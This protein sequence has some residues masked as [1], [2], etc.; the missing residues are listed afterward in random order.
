MSAEKIILSLLANRK[1]FHA[2]LEPQGR[3][4]LWLERFLT[5]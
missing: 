3:L 1:L 4:S 5:H 2:Y